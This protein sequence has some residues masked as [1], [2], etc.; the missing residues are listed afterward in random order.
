MIVAEGPAI[1]VASEKVAE[2]QRL[3]ASQLARCLAVE[4]QK[5]AQH[6]E[7]ARIHEI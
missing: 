5:I 4:P 2:A 7:E 6:Q 1:A 3:E